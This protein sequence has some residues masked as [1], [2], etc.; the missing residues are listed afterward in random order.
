M[1]TPSAPVSERLVFIW[2]M[3]SDRFISDTHTEIHKLVVQ[4]SFQPS[5]TAKNTTMNLRMD[6]IFFVGGEGWQELGFTYLLSMHMVFNV[7]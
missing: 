1:E 5:V 7:F 3:Y 4:I 2:Q 6:E